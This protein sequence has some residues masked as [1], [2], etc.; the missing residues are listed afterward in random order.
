MKLLRLFLILPVIAFSFEVEFLKKFSKD[1]NLDT[2]STNLI[3]TII[4]KDEN[5]VN[6]QLD[7]F[8]KKIKSYD[9][10]ERILDSFKIK[11]KYRYSKNTPKIVEHIGILRYQINSRKAK[12]MYE[13]ISE[14]SKLKRNRNTSIKVNKLSWRSREDTY[15]KILDSLRLK[16]IIWG[17]EYAK[18]LSEDIKKSCELKNV[19]IDTYGQ[20]NNSNENISNSTTEL[21]QEKI[22]INSKYVLECK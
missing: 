19:L 17:K 1:L 7:I 3:I 2:L 8:N 9:K 11:P 12:Y 5:I 15:N 16:A 18:N 13:F 20:D 4:D 10:V 14:I 22:K 6:E 21:N